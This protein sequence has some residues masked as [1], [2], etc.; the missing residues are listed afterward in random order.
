MSNA[1]D[2]FETLHYVIKSKFRSRET[3]F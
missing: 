3:W 1:L 2:C